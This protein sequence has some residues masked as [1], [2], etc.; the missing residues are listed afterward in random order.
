MISRSIA[1]FMISKGV[2]ITFVLF[3]HVVYAEYFGEFKDDLKGKFIETDPRPLFQL[4]SE[5]NFLDPNG[6]MWG[7]PAGEKVDGASIPS[8]FWSF[9]GGPFSGKYINA[10]VIHDYYCDVKTRTQHDT[11]RNFYYG[12]R[13]SSVPL[14]RAKLMYWTVATFGPKWELKERVVMQI[15]CV[16][17]GSAVVCNQAAKTITEPAEI[18]AVDLSDPVALA[19]ALGKAAA[20]A[21]SLRTTGGEVLDISMNGQLPATLDAIAQNSDYYRNVFT[22]KGYL[23][24][25]SKLGVLSRWDISRQ[26]A[27]GSGTV[28]LSKPNISAMNEME[29]IANWQ[30]DRL[31][32]YKDVA[33]IGDDT[34]QEILEGQGFKLNKQ[35]IHLMQQQLD[36]RVMDSNMSLPPTPEN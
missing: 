3:S 29:D 12:M 17:T 10:S 20:V 28:I 32:V 35:G 27:S 11:H 15:Q 5:F 2:I 30:Y 16:E 21:R 26:V 6:L 24:N 9:I 1:T 18:M 4:S 34:E 25:P 31:P 22:D 14:W 36:T 8:A 33:L 19:M 7:V 23:E 13:A